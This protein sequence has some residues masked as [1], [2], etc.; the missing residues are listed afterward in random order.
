MARL[1]C[2][3]RVGSRQVTGTGWG[4]QR[5]QGI[6]GGVL[7]SFYECR[8][9]SLDI[10]HQLHN[11]PFIPVHSYNFRKIELFVGLTPLITLKVAFWE[12]YVIEKLSVI[13]HC[14]RNENTYI[15]GWLDMSFSDLSRHGCRFTLSCIK[16]E[17]FN[18]K[19]RGKSAP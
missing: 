13:T 11:F 4:H 16:K 15:M 19:I 12:E 9:H 5:A 17:Y 3:S 2:T 7:R 14:N 10:F 18:W 8:R 1:G 6:F